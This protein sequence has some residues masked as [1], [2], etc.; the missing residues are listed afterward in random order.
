M[1][2]P[3][4]VESLAAL[5]ELSGQSPVNFAHRVLLVEGELCRL[6]GDAAGALRTFER[7]LTQALASDWVG[8][9]AIAHD[10]MARSLRVLGRTEEA[11]ERQAAARATYARWGARLLDP[12]G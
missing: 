9:V 1:L 10:L 7:A 3:R 5:R 2:R 8:E 4:I 6:E 11:D 12:A